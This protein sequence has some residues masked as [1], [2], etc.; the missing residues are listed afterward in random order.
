MKKNI[1][2]FRKK[3]QII[4]SDGSTYQLPLL[5]EKKQWKL[6]VDPKTN[7]VWN[8]GTKQFGLESKGQIAKFKKRFENKNNNNYNR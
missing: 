7:I 3:I 8:Y 5:M 4:E 1:H 6:E 2:P